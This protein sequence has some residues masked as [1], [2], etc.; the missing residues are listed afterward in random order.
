MNKRHLPGGNLSALLRAGNHGEPDT[1]LDGTAGLHDLQLGRDLR[2]APLGHLVQIHH[3]RASHELG[4]V[5]LFARGGGGGGE[6]GRSRGRFR[7]R[8]WFFFRRKEGKREEKEDLFFL[9]RVA[10]WR[11]V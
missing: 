1:V 8:C 7:F 4:H 10:F 5:V 6:E 3:G 11:D 9:Y 2:D